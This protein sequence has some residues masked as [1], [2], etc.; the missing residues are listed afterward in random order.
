M[1]WTKSTKKTDPTI[2]GPI[3]DPLAIQV[4]AKFLGNLADLEG[5]TW[6]AQIRRTVDASTAITMN[7]REDASSVVVTDVE[8]TDENPDGK[9][10]TLTLLFDLANTNQLDPDTEYVYG[11][12]AVEGPYAIWT[13]VAA[14]PIRGYAVV[15]RPEV[16]P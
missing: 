10:T 12:R 4:V 2:T 6:L 9:L 11:V 13:L 14:D 3:G 7:W 16:G 1:G 15:P 5:H 8:A